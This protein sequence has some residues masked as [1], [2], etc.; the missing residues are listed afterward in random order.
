M[1]LG[2]GIPV[3]ATRYSPI[4][5]PRGKTRLNPTGVRAWAEGRQCPWEMHGV[6]RLSPSGGAELLRPDYFATKPDGSAVH[7]GPDYVLPLW[8]KAPPR[9]APPRPAPPR[10]TRPTPAPS[11]PTPS[12]PTPPHPVPPHPAPPPS[13]GAG[14]R[15]HPRRA[16]RGAAQVHPL[17]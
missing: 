2:A 13:R 17:R 6:Y 10:P 11:H 1:Q 14:P 4:F 9:P 12:R 16:A 15:R 7:F 8:E 5:V 3:D